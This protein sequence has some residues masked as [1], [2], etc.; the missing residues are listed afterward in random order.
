[1]IQIHTFDKVPDLWYYKITKNGGNHYKK[2]K[3]IK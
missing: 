3:P 2:R 1:L